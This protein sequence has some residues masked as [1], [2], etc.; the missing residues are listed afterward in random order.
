MRMIDADFFRAALEEAAKINS[1][2]RPT[3]TGVIEAIGRCPTV[4]FGNAWISLEDN[5][6]THDGSYIIAWETP[7]GQFTGAAI[8]RN[9]TWFWAAGHVLYGVKLTHYMPFPEPPRKEKK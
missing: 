9:S 6:P 8:Y 3:W 4:E 1:G 5:P 2:K 7:A